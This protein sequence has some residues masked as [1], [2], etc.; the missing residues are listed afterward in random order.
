M[1]EFFTSSVFFGVFISLLS[2][3]IGTAL[4][5]RFKLAMFNPLLI[6][7]VLTTLLL[8]LLHIDYDT[9]YNGAKYISFLLTP[10]TVCLAVPL[11]EQLELLKKNF[12]ALIVGI[13]TGVCVSLSS[14]LLLSY[15]FSLDH[16]KY[17]T[18]LPKSITTAIGI[19]ISD[20]LGG[21]ISLTVAVIIITGIVGN[22]CAEGICRIFRITDPI[23]K[24]VAIGCSSHALG[25]TK[26]I[27]MGEIEGAMSSLAIV[28]SGILTVIIAPL[29]ASW[30]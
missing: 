14:V 28:V 10:A 9:Y 15:L 3:I 16:D 29:F 11:Y 25:T 19:G 27:E 6:A 21:Y 2:Y 5:K 12:V 1:S 4:K 26:A 8:L 17:V 18:L 22:V 7:I 20:E 13:A 30:L 23:A 24:G